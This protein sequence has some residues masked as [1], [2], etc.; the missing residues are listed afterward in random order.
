M[1]EWDL[2][3]LR[4]VLK[5]QFNEGELRNL[6]FDLNIDYDSLPGE[7]KADKA[8][9]LVAYCKRHGCIPELIEK[10]K[11]RRPNAPLEVLGELYEKG[12]QAMLAG[13][14]LT[15]I[16]YFEQ[17]VAQDPLYKNAKELLEESK[18]KLQREKELM[19]SYP[20]RVTR[21][22]SARALFALI[23]LFALLITTGV[24]FWSDI[25][26][27]LDPPDFKGKVCQIKSDWD[28]NAVF[29]R[30]AEFSKLELPIGSKVTIA[31]RDTGKRV[32]NVTLSLNSDLKVCSVR[33]SELLRQAL[34]IKD[35]TE[36]QPESRRPNRKFD[37]TQ[38]AP[39]TNKEIISFS[40]KVCMIKKEQ[41]ADTL[42][43]RQTEFNDL[44]VPAGTTVSITVHD[45]DKTIQEINLSLDKDLEICAIRLS[46]DYRQAL[47]VDD[48]TQIEPES[49]RPDRQISIAIP[50]P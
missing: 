13:Q 22:L 31:V 47:G 10:V 41:D 9:E 8:R 26:D 11:R 50:R 35:D 36:I 5:E 38:T 15:A 44:H 45:T 20:K 25:R 23:V 27:L 16:K 3:Q 24:L 1:E 4:K 18:L 29:L 42:F 19:M 39:P 21:I 48:D 14:W 40:G 30:Q 6:C 33:L 32:E 12:V 2:T 34:D 49:N 28:T 37:I 7:G 17:V 46:E 43:L